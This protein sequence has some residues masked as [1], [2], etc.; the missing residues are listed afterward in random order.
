MA[1]SRKILLI[2]HFA[3]SPYHGME[4]R[5]YY[6]AK[7]WVQ[8]G[9]RVTIVA[10]SYSHHR[11]N[12]PILPTNT[13]IFEEHIDGIRYV[14]LRTPQ[15]KTSGSSRI[16]NMLSFVRGLFAYHHQIVGNNKTDVVIASSTY[17]FDVFPAAYLA[18]CHQARLVYEIHDLWPEAV[19]DVHQLPR[20]HPYVVS[21]GVAAQFAYRFTDRIVSIL[22]NVGAFLKRRG[23][24]Q[25][26]IVHV[27]N[28]ID[29][30]QWTHRPIDGPFPLI[31]RIT[32]MQNNG[33]F[34]LGY[35][36][37]H[38]AANALFQLLD[39][40]EHTQDTNI[41]YLL[42]GS[43]SDKESLKEYARKR[44]LKNVIF[45]DP[46]PKLDVPGVLAHMDALYIGWRPLRVYQYGISPNKLFDYMASGRPIIHV[47]NASNDPVAVAKCGISV[48]PNHFARIVEAV[49]TLA[50][51]PRAQRD[52]IGQRGREYVLT[53]HIYPVLADTFLK[54]VF[55][56]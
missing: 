12:N 48:H 55:D 38:G 47:V 45:E 7:E 28:G 54:G 53:H 13:F 35:V 8:R 41:V 2:N 30:S 44:R 24:S 31:D 40:A 25:D 23:V 20:W 5:P 37:T 43:G 1:P 29:P 32:D 34:V 14:W 39:V 52:T 36:G 17:P 3:G 50:A 27:P 42:V 19:A 16:N 49:R 18:H 9:H 56:T 6:L 21:A 22:P 26:K 51:M 4:F 46:V 10:A 11:F 33:H 15:Y